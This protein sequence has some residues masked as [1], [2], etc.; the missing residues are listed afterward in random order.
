MI[1]EHVREVVARFPDRQ[2]HILSFIARCGEAA[3]DLA[4]ANPALAWAMA[5]N[6]V[7][8]R[9]RVQR[10]LRSARALLKAGKKQ[11]D[12]LGWL[13]FPATEAGRKTLRKVVHQTIDV[14]ALLYLR[15][16]MAVP[17]VT[18]VLGHVPR[19]NRGVIRV[20]S[21][22]ELFTLVSPSLL[23]EIS[24]SRDNDKQPKAAWLLQDSLN[25][26]RL[27]RVGQGRLPHVKSLVRLAEFHDSLV[28]DVGH[29]RLQDIEIAFPP[30]P[31]KG[32]DTIIPLTTARDLVSEGREQRNCVASYIDRVAIQRRIYIYRTIPPLDRC[33]LSIMKRGNRWTLC[34]LKR[35]C[36][37]PPTE[38]TRHAV[39]RWLA[40]SQ[41]TDA[42]PEW[43]EANNDERAQ[44][45]DG[46]R[47]EEDGPLPEPPDD[48]VPF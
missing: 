35:T 18:R 5:S 21:D 26:A 25:M 42:I 20:V 12:I 22:P 4:V 19:I 46:H 37:M 29:A 23:E 30:P 2:W 16:S 45:Q 48:E 10:P 8:H 28:E 39:L 24:F 14:S 13:G 31:V 40:E 33:T 17:E 32:T 1:P 27:L 44:E 36:N 41:P 43:M 9:P 47:L 34:E 3:M 15:Q 38:T 11:R 6:W 7:F